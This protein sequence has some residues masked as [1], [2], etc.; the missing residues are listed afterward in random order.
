M[1]VENR[2]KTREFDNQFPVGKLPGDI[3]AK[4]WLTYPRTNLTCAEQTLAGGFHLG[5]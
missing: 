1:P 3:V 4:P 2:A 5:F